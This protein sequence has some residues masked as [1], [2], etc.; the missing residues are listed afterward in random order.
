MVKGINEE[1]P[2]LPLELYEK[3]KNENYGLNSTC[4]LYPELLSIKFHS[5]F[6]QEFENLNV[7]FELFGAYYDNRTAVPDYPVIRILGMVNQIEEKFPTSYCQLWY[8]KQKEPIIV[9]ITKY[10]PIWHNYWGTNPNVLYPHLIT[11]VLPRNKLSEVPQ[12]VSIVAEECERATNHLKVIYEPPVGNRTKGGF[13]VCVKNLV[14]P[15]A[16]TS[17]RLVEW[18]EMLRILGA[19]EVIV[20][21]LAVHPNATKVMDYYKETGFLKVY[22]HS[23]ARGEPVFPN[24]QRFI[25]QKD[26]LN[27]VLNEMFPYNDC[28]YRNLYKYDYLAGIDT[29]E[30]IMPLGNWTSWYDIVEYVQKYESPN[31]ETFADICFRNTYYPLVQSTFSTDIPKYFHMLQHVKRVK[32]H[33]PVGWATK[34]LHSTNYALTLHN[35]YSMDWLGCGGLEINITDAQLQHYRDPDDKNTLNLTVLDSNIWRFKENLVKRS[36]KVFEELDFFK[37][38]INEN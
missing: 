29:D 38:A 2:M 16:D 8:E 1:L 21:S 23:Y 3:N 6:Y 4:A 20:Y 24:F 34:C 31:C 13:A 28:F 27:M 36:L 26:Y 10:L 5:N 35:H 18:M 37:K 22:P 14:F 12:S 15:F 32:E 25:M 33:M 7:T 30:V 19:Q 9:P 17:A 11:C